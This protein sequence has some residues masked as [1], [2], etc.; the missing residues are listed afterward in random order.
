MFIREMSIDEFKN[1]ANT[2]FIGN[3]HESINY[4]LLKAEEGY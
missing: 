1:F 4:A 3:F 2:H